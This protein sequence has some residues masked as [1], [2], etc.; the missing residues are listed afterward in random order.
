MW[1]GGGAH[2]YA[3][4]AILVLLTVATCCKF[5]NDA[6]FDAI[7]SVR[8]EASGVVYSSNEFSEI[9]RIMIYSG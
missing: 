8:K 1:V 6:L 9:N 2:E 4:G 5:S 3:R 7:L